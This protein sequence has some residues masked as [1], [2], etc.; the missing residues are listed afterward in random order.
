MYCDSL[1][2]MMILKN[3]FQWPVLVFEIG[4]N[5]DFQVD[6]EMVSVETGS[7]R[8]R[9]VSMTCAYVRDE[10]KPAAGAA[11]SGSLPPMKSVLRR[12]D[13]CPMCWQQVALVA[14]VISPSMSSLGWVTSSHPSSADS[15]GPGT[16]TTA[17]V[18]TDTRDRDGLTGAPRIVAGA[19]ATTTKLPMEC[20][21]SCCLFTTRFLFF[22]FYFLLGSSWCASVCLKL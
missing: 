7:P 8:A 20:L 11:P 5:K 16:G 9:T 2:L 1:N 12:A 19:V 6:W 15:T 13:D 3:K 10:T 18:R 22:F 4:V 14:G 21:H 17:A